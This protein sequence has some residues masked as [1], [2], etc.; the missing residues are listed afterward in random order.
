M[1]VAKKTQILTV[2][3]FT[4]G[5]VW[6]GT[7]LDT[8]EIHT[9]N[10]LLVQLNDKY[11]YYSFTKALATSFSV[12]RDIFFMFSSNF[13]LGTNI[14]RVAMTDTFSTEWSWLQSLSWRTSFFSGWRSEVSGYRCK[15]VSDLCGVILGF[16]TVP[17]CM[18]CRWHYVWNYV[19]HFLCDFVMTRFV[20]YYFYLN[21]CLY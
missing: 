18:V 4:I 5:P 9:I 19:R 16:R 7:N 17:Q 1:S 21:G 11:N 13:Y 6:Q 3:I 8:G 10:T 2:K 20:F 12:S 15:E 14:D